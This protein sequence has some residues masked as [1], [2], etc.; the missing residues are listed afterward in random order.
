LALGLS[1]Y[2]SIGEIT[3][4]AS[5]V[6]NLSTVY[7]GDV[8]AVELW[9]GGLSEDPAPG[10]LVGTT[11][12][13]V[14]AQQFIALRDGDPN[15]FE[16]QNFD[17]DMMAQIRSTTLSDL[18]LRNTDTNAMQD[19]AFLAS[20]RVASDAVPD[21]LEMPRLV[22]G[23]DEDA[24]GITGGPADDTIVAGSGLVQVLTGGSGADT[25]QF[26]DGASHQVTVSDFTPG[27]DRLDFEA[28]AVR[29]LTFADL[30]V[31][32]DDSGC[33]VVSFGENAITLAGVLPTQFSARDVIF[34]QH[35]VGAATIE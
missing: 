27:L 4:D 1:P 13:A 29:G 11:F 31:A 7:Q 12:Q 18:I 5:V 21:E 10:A 28:V 3:T 25:F 17:A 24:A 6:A 26:L 2:T 16:A 33:V 30:D 8:N 22:I 35:G 9:I 34:D 19:N 20:V 23:T 15:W 14:I 32:T